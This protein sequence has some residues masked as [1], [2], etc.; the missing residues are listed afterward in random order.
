MINKEDTL[1]LLQGRLADANAVLDLLFTL[2]STGDMEGLR[3]CSLSTALGT[4]IELV[5]DAIGA[6]SELS[7][8]RVTHVPAGGWI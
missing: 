2:A 4:V 7:A 5:D 1:D 3:Q 8:N 6:A